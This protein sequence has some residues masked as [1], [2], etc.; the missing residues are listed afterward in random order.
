QVGIYPLVRCLTPTLASQSSESRKSKRSGMFEEESLGMD[1][2]SGGN[3]SLSWSSSE[4]FPLHVLVS[5][6]RQENAADLC[7][8]KVP[9]GV[10]LRYLCTVALHANKVKKLLKKDGD[11]NVRIEGKGAED[12]MS[13]DF[14]AMVV[15]LMLHKTRKIYTLSPWCKKEVSEGGHQDT[16]DSSEGVTPVLS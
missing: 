15:H 14:D 12:K 4:S 3:R 6:K 11:L 9:Q 2:D 13:I 8:I 7:L 16:Y 10:S 1:N 5:P